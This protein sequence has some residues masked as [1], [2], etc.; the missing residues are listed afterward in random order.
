M[1]ATEPSATLGFLNS[2]IISFLPV[3]GI[4]LIIASLVMGIRKRKRRAA[5]APTA[6]EQ[7]ERTQQ[8]QGMRD[9]L[10][11]LMVEI[12]QLAKRL[13]SQLDT[14]TVYLEKVISEADEKIAQLQR[15][16]DEV[17]DAQSEDASA[18]AR[19]ASIA[20]RTTAG[21]QGQ[22]ATSQPGPRLSQPKRQAVGGAPDALTQSVYDLADQGKPASE[23]ASELNEHIGKIEL[24]LALRQT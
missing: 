18:G 5:T 21:G 15:L 19:R 10:Q 4:L 8:Q 7:L 17:E 12:E 13:S 11:S 22:T 2:T 1:L 6:R 14:K 9:D 24:I 3:I 23:I 16:R 20:G